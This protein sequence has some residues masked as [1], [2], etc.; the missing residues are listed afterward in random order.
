MQM[1]MLYIQ[2]V[3]FFLVPQLLTLFWR[4]FG[5]KSQNQKGIC[6]RNFVVVPNLGAIP[7]QRAQINR[8]NVC[9]S[10]AEFYVTSGTWVEVLY[11]EHVDLLDMYTVTLVISRIS[12][13]KQVK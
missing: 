1:D 8:K 5:A 11:T 3:F 2:R 12:R 10:F 4:T 6:C 9:K 13:T 7:A